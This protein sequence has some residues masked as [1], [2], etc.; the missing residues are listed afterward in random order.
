MVRNMSTRQHHIKTLGVCIGA[1]TI[2]MVELIQE[3]QGKR[4]VQSRY[5]E[6]RGAPKDTFLHLLK[7]MNPDTHRITVTGRKFRDI[8]TFHKI[9]EPESVEFALDYLFPNQDYP[10]ALVSAGGESFLVYALNREGKVTRISSGNKC[11]S[12][13]GEF[14]LQQIK[15]M[16]LIPEQ[17]IQLADTGTPH[18]VSGRCSVFC[19]SDCTHALNKGVPIADVTA[20]LSKMIAKKII[21]LLV[22]VD[23]ERVMI[24]GGMAKNPVIIK[25]VQEEIPTVIVP[26][27]A[28]C[29]EALGAA[30]SAFEDASQPFSGYDSLFA[31]RQASFAFMKPIS[32][33]ESL[34]DFKHTQRGMAS[35]GDEC[36]LGVDVG[37]TTTKAVLMRTGDQKILASEY[38]RTS[39]DPVGASR[40]CYASLLKQ[41]PQ[42]VEIIGLGVTGSGR[43]I[44]G[45]HALTDG[46]I[47]E[48]IAH[49][50]AATFFDPD[51]DTIFEIGGQDAKY[52]YLVNQVPC[53]YA[54]NEACSAGTGSFLEESAYESLRIPMEGIA[55]IALKAQAPPNFSDQCA[56][57]ISSDIKTALQEG[58][59]REDIVAGLVYSICINYN[60]RVKGNRNVG[61]KIFFQGGVCYNRSIPLAMAGLTGREIIV[62]PEPGL[63]GAFGVA[64]EV[65][66]KLDLALLERGSFDL[67]TLANREIQM[68][69]TFICAGGKE[70]CDRQCPINMYIVEGKKYPFGGACNKYYNMIHKL[71]YDI[72]QLDFVDKRYRLLYETYAKPAESSQE[73][74]LRIGMNRSFEI[75]TLYPLFFNFFT[76]LGC[77]VVLSDVVHE[78]GIEK[79]TTALC[80]PAQIALGLFEDLLQKEPDYIFLPHIIELHVAKEKKY[81]QEFQTTCMMVQGEPFYLKAAFKNRTSKGKSLD[82]IVLHPTLNLASGFGAERE[83]LI[84]LGK[85]L[86]FTKNACREALD[87]AF[88]QQMAFF[89]EN[90]RNAEEAIAA[91]EQ[92]PDEIGIVLFGRSYNALAPD[93][94]KGI[95]YKF[96]SRGIRIIPYDALPFQN[97]PNYKGTYWEIGQRILRGAQIVKRHPQLFGTYV[98]NFMCALDSVLVQHFRDIMGQKPSL[99]LEVDG[100]TADAGINT[101]IDAVL[102]VIANYRQ[103]EKD[104]RTIPQSS[105]TP[106]TYRRAMVDVEGMGAMY[107]DSK[108]ARIKLTDPRVKVIIP[109]MGEIPTEGFATVFKSMGIRSE[110]LPAFDNEAFRMAMTYHNGKECLPMIILSGSLMKYLKYRE[111][112]S[113]KLAYFTVGSGGNC[114]V[115]QYNIFLERLI[116]Q[117]GWEDVAT[118][119]LNN[120]EAYAGLGTQFRMAAWTILVIAD[121]MEDI[122][123]VVRSSAINPEHAEAIFFREWEQI[124]RAACGELAWDVME[125]IKRTVKVFR[126]QIELKYPLERVK[127]IGLLGEIYV[128]HDVFSLQNIP[129][130]LAEKGFAAKISPVHEWIIYM[131]YCIKKGYQDPEYTIGGRIEA[132]ISNFWQQSRERSI[133]KIFSTSGLYNEKYLDVDK[134]IRHSTH[135][136]PAHLKGEPGLSSGAALSKMLEEYCGIINIGPFGCNNS[137]LTESILSP[138]MSVAGKK[139][140]IS[141]ASEPYRWDGHYKDHEVLPLFSI[142]TDGNPFPQI[143]E[144]QFENFCIQA[145]RLH[146]K[147]MKVHRLV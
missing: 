4:I 7:E 107:I 12:G 62:P 87:Y 102:D 92:N 20:G 45:L 138:E 121:I 119:A 1:S 47:N 99:T 122:R 86:G 141:N 27:Q 26:E 143:I 65:Q 134:Y 133:K 109:S 97:E 137:R 5:E 93:A 101:R 60:N 131:D 22:K 82:E 147:M 88:E 68:G 24:V 48:I 21:E 116:E 66:K 81:R 146:K 104:R 76:H 111:H 6:H 140:A 28:F 42:H 114:R 125:Q 58:I 126:E 72:E 40:K 117:K 128:R 98:T 30:L 145:D 103:L 79:A 70:K 95:P 100:H 84:Q 108:G 23:T 14:F 18:H 55:D 120:E 129:K 78:S 15:R 13:T 16:D 3:E 34:V 37:S 130:R 32:Q 96:A 36:I 89:G 115:G 135:L 127:T 85:R 91:L 57:F 63:M 75:H 77:E 61:N 80:Y 35:D 53:D 9:T 46:V 67:S 136:V 38:L 71:D 94:N 8:V 69:K 112:S 73:K 25:Y 124:K 19:K 110:A 49:A 59:S 52:T 64:L 142:E 39:G 33:Y 105:R 113:E 17:A 144:A 29:F 31:T 10:T 54:M 83:E 51:V 106:L 44:A 118:L 123:W 2:S 11:A 139:R 41:V 56:A 50:S 43:Q 74:P 90:N 132:I